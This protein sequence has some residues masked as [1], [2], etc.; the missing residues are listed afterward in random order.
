VR[1]LVADSNTLDVLGGLLAPPAGNGPH[2]T[3]ALQLLWMENQLRTAPEGAW[4]FTVMH[5]PP[6]SPRGCVF[7]FLGQC[8]G[9]HD[10]ES[11]LKAQL[12]QAWGPAANDRDNGRYHP[13]FV[14][15][16]H[17][18][19]YARTRALDALGYPT[20]SAAGGVR[21]FVTGGGGAPLYRQQP[22]HARYAFGG[23]FHHFVYMRLQKDVAFFWAVD[24]G[25]HARD[26]GCLRRG[27][28][29]DRCIAQGT[30]TS[31]T[32]VCGEPAAGEGSCPAPRP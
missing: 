13:D 5:H 23:S 25:G 14:F 32:L 18:H 11:T 20:T 9:G 7:R 29:L 12:L 28:T 6:F 17:N 26:S 31:A 4:T 15:T 2:R 27:E 24:D 19:F 21:Y 16:A 10:D 3:D 8:V 30:Y 22:L 1:V